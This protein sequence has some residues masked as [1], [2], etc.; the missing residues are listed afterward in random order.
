MCV[1]VK[2]AIESYTKELNSVR[3]RDDISPNSDWTDC[4]LSAPGEHDDFSFIAL[5]LSPL[6]SHHFSIVFIFS[7]RCQMASVSLPSACYK[8]IGKGLEVSRY[9]S[10]TE[11]E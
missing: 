10:F 9:F 7:V 6:V 3:K 2:L 1:V 5:M 11:N 4:S 8:I